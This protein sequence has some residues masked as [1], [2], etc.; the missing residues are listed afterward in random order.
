MYSR[1]RSFVFL[2]GLILIL[3]VSVAVHTAIAKTNLLKKSLYTT[4]LY[5]APS[6]SSTPPYT[7]W[8]TAAHDIQ[9]AIDAAPLGALILVTNGQYISSSQI[10]VTNG[11]TVR[12]ASGPEYTIING[13]GTHRGFYIDHTDAIID[14]FTI[15]NG[16]SVMGSDSNS[17]GG[18]V[19][20]KDGTLRN[21]WI[22][23]NR[24][25]RPDDDPWFAY[26]GGV[27]AD[28][29]T[30]ENCKIIGN[31]ISGG[32]GNL[33]P[34]N[35]GEGYG[36][37][38]HACNGSR[39]RNCI[40]AENNVTASHGSSG[41]VGAYAYGGG[42]S[43]TNYGFIQD[44]FITRNT[45][46][47]G[48]G[49]LGNA[50]GLGGG[51]FIA[52]E[53]L[54]ENCR[55]T[56]NT[57]SG[58]AGYPSHCP[59]GSAG[60]GVYCGING[61]IR[62]CRIIGNIARGDDGDYGGFASGG[63]VFIRSNATIQSSLILRNQAIGGN[64]TL[65]SGDAWGGGIIG[66]G[67]IQA[68]TIAD[69]QCIAGTGYHGNPSGGGGVY[70]M[71]AFICANTIIRGNHA[72]NGGG[73]YFSQ[74]G[75]L[76]NCLLTCNKADAGGG[77]FS[78]ND[79]DIIEHCTIV[80]NTA[81]SN[82]GGGIY[83]ASGNCTV[84]YSIV[85]FN[86]SALTASSNYQSSVRFHYSCMSP[87]SAGAGNL[88]IDPQFVDKNTL[89]LKLGPNSPLIDKA[90]NSIVGIDLI[91][92]ARPLDGNNDGNAVSDIGAYEY[93]NQSAD[94]DGDGYRDGFE[95]GRHS[96]PTQPGSTPYA[97]DDF[98]GDR[99]TDLACY[100]Q[101]SGDWYIRSLGT[102]A[103]ITFGQNWG[104]SGM[105]PVPGDYNGD[106]CFD[107][108]AYE[109]SSGDWYI[110]SLG[111]GAPIAFGQNWGG[112][113]FT[114]V[115]GDYN[116]D[117][118]FDLAIYNEA[119]GQWFIRSLGDMSTPVITFG[120]NWGGPGMQAVSG[121][122]DGDGIFDMALYQESTGNWYIKS[123]GMGNPITFGQN[124]GGPGLIPIAGDFNADGLW[125][126]AVYQLSSGNWYICSL[127][128]VGPANPPIAFG[129]NW[130]GAGIIPV[131]GDYNQDG[132][133]DLSTYQRSTGNWFIR[134]IELS[135]P[136]NPPITF[137]QNWGSWT[138]RPV[139][140]AW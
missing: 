28:G 24:L 78:A 47:G 54:I 120:Q 16:F 8:Q 36:G 137:G 100:E 33:G 68:C 106:G 116:G 62:H 3:I 83:N 88:A 13:N 17:Y 37:G 76:R 89:Q 4:V 70:G 48:S 123:L 108:C 39:V 38:I 21:C 131:T 104:N 56:T 14:G 26:G 2:G 43:A 46:I 75:R 84:L 81:T 103:P 92:I 12:S 109:L 58:P 34:L 124:W 50:D 30:V 35:A 118:V 5:V 87:Y 125:D 101:S 73:V 23:G 22:T 63:G 80:S 74:N 133:H 130:G 29:A 15:T 93:I 107:M 136:A 86:S 134:S 85:Y 135:S 65:M 139:G 117:K 51:I 10:L 128:P 98:N 61:H 138:T 126:L 9:P 41:Y 59:G 122:Y 55:I 127:G 45:V 67:I 96:N 11:V 113:G 114:P 69:N 1:F 90:F 18:G 44:C 110:K 132:A 105:L 71:D 115:P 79:G 64:G 95:I 6:G 82:G 97:F 19:Y 140:G 31:Q 91:G 99:I 111:P 60:G 7:S 27:Y 25:G 77:I 57:A 42:I 40:I 20:C 102:G 53:I 129:Q 32:Y 94:S 112:P 121:D 52:G 66:R 49:Q 119:T 72:P